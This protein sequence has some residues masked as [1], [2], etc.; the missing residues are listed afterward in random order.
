M[1]IMTETEHYLTQQ[2]C[3]H[4]L[5]SKDAKIIRSNRLID[6]FNGFSK[7]GMPC[8][9]EHKSDFSGSKTIRNL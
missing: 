9:K 2:H 5:R 7:G 1:V 6:Q 3:S 4:V 8:H